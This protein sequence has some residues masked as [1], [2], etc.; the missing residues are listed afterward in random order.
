MLFLFPFL[1]LALDVDDISV[2]LEVHR[3]EGSD[4]QNAFCKRIL[5]CVA[6]NNASMLFIFAYLN[7]S[8][9][10]CHSMY[11]HGILLLRPAL[12]V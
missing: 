11:R 4:Q 8:S 9:K 6:R 3:V 10:Y 5:H 2:Y 7:Y 12:V 1:L